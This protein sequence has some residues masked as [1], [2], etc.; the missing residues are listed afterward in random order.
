MILGMLGA[1]PSLGTSTAAVLAA[2]T[3]IEACWA[4][5]KAA[6]KGAM[7]LLISIILYLLYAVLYALAMASLYWLA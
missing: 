4:G 6:F 2:I 5:L 3:T 1:L 7:P